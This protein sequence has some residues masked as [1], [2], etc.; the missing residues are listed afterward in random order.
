VYAE[1]TERVSKERAM[2]R[3]QFKW[4][5]KRLRELAAMEVPHEEM[6]MNLGAARARAPTAWRLVDIA[7]DQPGAKF[8]YTLNRQKLRRIRRREGRYLLR[9]NLTENDPA[10]L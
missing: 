1:S 3:R 6:L 10:L 9:T 8:S 4:L 5:W 7:M 2:R